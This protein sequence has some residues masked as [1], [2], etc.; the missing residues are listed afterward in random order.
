MAITNSKLTDK[1]LHNSIGSI[2]FNRNLISLD[3][4]G[5]KLTKRGVDPLIKICVQCGFL[6]E[7]A[8]ENNELKNSGFSMLF[9]TV[10]TLLQL[11]KA[12]LRNNKISDKSVKLIKSLLN[13]KNLSLD[14]L[15]LCDNEFG[16]DGI[17]SII[18]SWE[19]KR[20]RGHPI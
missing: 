14:N 15:N 8:L 7:L 11:K 3:L 1:N 6:Q 19:R 2:A 4:S 18:R 5:N 9:P 20:A 13:I 17:E 12:N 16:T 10:L